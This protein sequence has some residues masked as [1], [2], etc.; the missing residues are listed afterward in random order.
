[1]KKLF[2]LF[3]FLF[4]ASNP[5][6]TLAQD[7]Y[8][9][10]EGVD[11]VVS[12]AD[13]TQYGYYLR[14][15]VNGTA[16]FWAAGSTTGNSLASTTSSS[17]GATMVSIESSGDEFIIY[18]LSDDARTG[19]KFQST[20]GIV[21]WVTSNGASSNYVWTID[22]L[23]D[24]PTKFCLYNPTDNS[25]AL[26]A[27]SADQTQTIGSASTALYGTLDNTNA[28]FQWE[29][30]PANDAAK[31]ATP[32]D[33][34]VPEAETVLNTRGVGYPTTTSTVYTTLKTAIDNAN[35]GTASALL[36]YSALNDYKSETSEIQMPEDGKT[37]VFT[38]VHPAG[39]NHYI[40]YTSDGLTLVARGDGDAND[41]PISAKFI[42]RVV[43]NKYVFANNDGVYL[44]WRGSN[45][46]TN[47]VK[48]YVSTYDTDYCPMTFARMTAT[49]NATNDE[50]LFGIMCFGGKR[51]ASQDSYFVI[52][53]GDSYSFNQNGSFSNL[54]YSENH[55][56]AFL[57]E[58][59]D[60]PNTVNL[61]NPNID[62]IATIGTFSAP[63]PTVIPED[64]TA[65]YVST[66]GDGVA[67]MKAVEGEAIPAKTGVVL[68][69]NESTVT[70]ALMLPAT[71]ETAATIDGNLLGNTAGEALTVDDNNTTIYI[72][73]KTSSSS[74]AQFYLSAAGTISMNKAYLEGEGLA[75]S[76]GSAPQ[77]SL[78][79]GTA[80]GIDAATTEKADASKVIYD[81][82]GRRVQKAVKGLYIMNGKKVYVK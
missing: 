77:L 46:G 67:T 69:G 54:N 78:N 19:L 64:V 45:A 75:T 12:T 62:G 63:F 35:N 31:N 39:I 73:S 59:V 9:T 40:N 66:A 18:V 10:A 68:T 36:I 3:A 20:G 65:Y 27:R 81:L 14:S 76:T 80:T 56:T 51:D 43:D 2:Y 26:Y 50:D 42:C 74:S 47:D 4:V 11:P 22:P 53:S 13:G 32:V 34:N 41:L 82:S 28:Q 15:S 52:T 55:S 1:M 44:V 24:D 5:M 17:S 7:D 57:I 48:G 58:E 71:S 21:M 6:I 16:T 29:F 33:V 49:D 30:I 70:S 60:Y 23:D 61:N 8:T 38:N 37:Y 72:L 79:F 25:K